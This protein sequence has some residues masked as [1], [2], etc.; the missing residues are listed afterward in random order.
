MLHPPN[1]PHASGIW[2]PPVHAGKPQTG[3]SSVGTALQMPNRGERFLC[4][5]SLAAPF[6]H[7]RRR[8]CRPYISWKYRGL[9]NGRMFCLFSGAENSSVACWRDGIR[10]QDSCRSPQVRKEALEREGS[11]GLAAGSCSRRTVRP[12]PS[13]PFSPR[14]W[15]EAIK[16]EADRQSGPLQLF[17]HTGH[18]STAFKTR[19][20]QRNLACCLR[21]AGG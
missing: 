13:V 8:R 7:S 9:E 19:R 20:S 2:Y 21:L 1:H 11:S 6:S 3:H 15:P 5:T 12:S 4:L 17:I 14:D 16:A 10:I 18:M